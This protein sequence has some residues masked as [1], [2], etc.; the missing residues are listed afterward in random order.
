MKL[1]TPSNTV[2]FI[3]CLL[4]IVVIVGRFFP[5]VHIPIL[6]TFV[7]TPEMQFRVLIVAWLALFGGL[8][9]NY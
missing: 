6:A 4:V 2:F 5:G 1:H 7:E 9:F 8:I 3:S